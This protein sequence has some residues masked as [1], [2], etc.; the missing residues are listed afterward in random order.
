VVALISALGRQRQVD[1]YVEA[2]LIYRVSSRTTRERQRNPVSTSL[3]P[4]KKNG[5]VLTKNISSKT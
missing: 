2:S 3:P 4:K 5:Y 1:L